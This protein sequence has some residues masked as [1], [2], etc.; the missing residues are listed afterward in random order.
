MGSDMSQ[1]KPGQKSPCTAT[2]TAK[3]GQSSIE[4]LFLMGIMAAIFV[5]ITFVSYQAQSD[6]AA[7]SADF[8]AQRLCRELA[9]RISAVDAAGNGTVAGLGMPGKI[10]GS[11]FTILVSGPG[12]RLS[13]LYAK[14]VAGCPLSTSNIANGTGTGSA[15]KFYIYGGESKSIKNIGQGVVVD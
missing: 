15:G 14:G 10:A 12:R 3:L 7:L 5:I 4:F 11:N 1:T 8:E 2:K 13:I 6:T 9:F